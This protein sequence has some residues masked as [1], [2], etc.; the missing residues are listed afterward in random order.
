MTFQSLCSL[1]VIILGVYNREV[2]DHETSQP[3]HLVKFRFPSLALGSVYHD[4]SLL[5]SSMLTESALRRL[6]TG[7]QVK[8]GPLPQVARL[9]SE[10][11]SSVLSA[12]VY[13]YSCHMTSYG[14][15]ALTSL[16][17][18]SARMASQGFNFDVFRKHRRRARKYSANSVLDSDEISEDEE[19]EEDGFEESEEERASSL[20]GDVISTGERREMATLLLRKYEDGMKNYLYSFFL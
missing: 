4:P 8:I 2:Y 1:E 6:E 20:N 9:D 3:K 15:A 11:R 12:V 18:A 5:Q 17:V 16:C 10:N 14:H 7:H 13:C 19:L